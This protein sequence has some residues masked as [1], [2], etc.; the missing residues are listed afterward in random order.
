MNS[1]LESVLFLNSNHSL[2]AA[3]LSASLAPEISR[4][5]H[6]RAKRRAKSLSDSNR[7]SKLY[8]LWLCPAYGTCR[9]TFQEHHCSADWNERGNDKTTVGSEHTLVLGLALCC[10]YSRLLSILHLGYS[11][12]EEYAC[13][14]NLWEILYCDRAQSPVGKASQWS[15][16]PTSNLESG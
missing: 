2:N 5:K 12:V 3:L 1:L 16:H 11:S 10:T 8:Y 6:C 15:V 9:M 7:A 14:S 13:Q 4:I